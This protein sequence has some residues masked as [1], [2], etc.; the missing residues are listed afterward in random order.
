MNAAEAEILL[1]A[2]ALLG[3]SL[4]LRL[5]ASDP[6]LVVRLRDDD[7]VVVMGAGPVWRIGHALVERGESRRTGD[8]SAPRR[9]DE[10]R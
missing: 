7:L 8:A 9:E 6:E 2:P 1:L 4:A 10:T 5:T 3:E